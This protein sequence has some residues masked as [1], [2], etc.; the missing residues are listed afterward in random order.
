LSLKVLVRDVVESVFKVDRKLPATLRAVVLPGELTLDYLGGRRAR[1]PR[2]LSLFFVCARLFFLAWS[3]A[4]HPVKA[5]GVRLG[6]AH[7]QFEVTDDDPAQDG[8]LLRAARHPERVERL[9]AD[10]QSPRGQILQV[11]AMALALAMVTRPRGFLFSEHLVFA[12]HVA[13]VSSLVLA[14]CLLVHAPNEL[15]YGLGFL[16]ELVAFV[17]VYRFG[18]W[19]TTWR[20]ASSFVL[21]VLLGVLFV[22]PVFALYVW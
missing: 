12:L 6:L 17:R 16:Y 2:P 10:L 15:G 8:L 4:P 14:L 5:D 22:V 18:W 20:F 21:M 11:F 9:A 1:Y 7:A 13:S 19:G 3:H